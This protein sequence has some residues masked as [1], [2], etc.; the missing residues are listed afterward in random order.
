[1]VCTNHISHSFSIWLLYIFLRNFIKE[2][3][4]ELIEAARADGASEF[5]FIE[6]SYC[7]NEASLAALG[8]LILLYLE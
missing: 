7:L 6:R 3:P 2:L 8:V 1:M 5:L 4:F